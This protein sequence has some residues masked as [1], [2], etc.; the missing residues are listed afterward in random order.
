MKKKVSIIMPTYNSEK[1]IEESLRSIRNQTIDQNQVEILI[2]D[3]GSKDRTIEIAKKYGARIINNERKLP[4]FAKQKGILEANA[5]YGIFIDSDE[6]FMRND[7]LERRVSFL[8]KHADVKNL[9]STGMACYEGEIGINRYANYI[10][11]PFSNFMYKYNGYDRRED[12]QRFYTYK[13]EKEGYIFNIDKNGIIPLYD[14]LGNMFD[15]D[16][17]HNVY[18][19]MKD[20]RS[21]AANIFSNMV[22]ITEKA[23]MLKDDYVFHRPGLTSKQYLNKLKWRIKNNLFQE[24]GVGYSAR[25]KKNSLLKRR[26]V[27][28]V[29]YCATFVPVIIHSLFLCKKNDDLYFLN[30]FIY[31]EYVFWSIVWFYLLKIF[32]ISIKK[33][34]T[35]GKR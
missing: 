14:A 34:S 27:M 13:E 15:L 33:D 26:E 7:S 29:I 20:N 19:N 12:M 18:N 8:D 2:V 5:K 22:S 9:V 30:H 28:F 32:K 25:Q 4:E 11:D 10:G 35:Y 24:E 17:A 1:T 31:T 23:A 3:G 21:F 16:Y 6:A